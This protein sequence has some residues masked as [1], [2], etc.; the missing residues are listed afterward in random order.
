M[1]ASLLLRQIWTLA[2][3]DLLL[4]LNTKRR[5]ST[6]FRALWIP[7]I[8]VIYMS[9]IIKVYWPK[10]TYG[11]GTPHAIRPLSQAIGEAVGNRR[12]L[13]LCN[14]GP[15]DGDIDRVIDIV[16]SKAR[17]NSGQIVQL[18]R[19]PEELLT[20]CKSSLSGVTKCYGA[21]EFYTS[22]SEGGIW[23]YTIRVDGAH[24][25]KINVDNNKN[26][27]EVFVIPLQHAI[28]AAI[29]EVSSGTGVDS[30]PE[31]V[32]A[33]PYTSK[34][35]KEWDDS[36][37]TSIQNAV[38]KYIAIVWYIG[39]IGLCY[40]LVGVMAREREDGMADLLESMMPNVNRW[41]PQFARL[42]GRWIAFTMVCSKLSHFLLCS[43]SLGLL[44]ILDS[45]CHHCE[46]WP[47]SENQPRYSYHLLHPLGVQS[48]FILYTWRCI[49]QAGTT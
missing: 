33:Y 3:K 27:A 6:F 45:D 7:T 14:Y 47:V 39:F 38:T 12:T 2:W 16:A 44:P 17:G 4:V 9:F 43:S 20:A 1:F 19:D 36:L 42:L 46:D 35:Q 25:F 18:L 22:P 31:H 13:A 15:N 32:E 40:H 5:T 37:V 26:D 23:N 49:L 41:E 48:E 24:G 28:D 34:T 30:L 10:E 21:A 11:I 8:F 29:A